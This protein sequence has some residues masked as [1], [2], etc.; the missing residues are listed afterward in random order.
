MVDG[1]A[2]AVNHLLVEVVLVT[3][4]VAHHRRLDWRATPTAAVAAVTRARLA[5]VI[6]LSLASSTAMI[7][8]AVMRI[9]KTQCA[10]R[11]PT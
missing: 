7:T 2:I 4:R 6:V 1:A 8:V 11:S 3:V 10:N 5:I 9:C